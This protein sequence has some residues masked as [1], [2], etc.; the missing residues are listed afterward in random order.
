MAGFLNEPLAI[1]LSHTCAWT[2]ARSLEALHF[3]LRIRS[4]NSFTRNPVEPRALLTQIERNYSA[5]GIKAE[6]M[7]VQPLNVGDIDGE[8]TTL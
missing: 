8:R 4:K 1:A 2:S 6:S 3:Q 5:V 7:S